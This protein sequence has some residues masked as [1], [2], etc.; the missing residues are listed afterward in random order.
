MNSKTGNLIGFV[1]MI[2]FM[3]IVFISDNLPNNSSP[4]PTPTPNQPQEVSPV[5]DWMTGPWPPLSESDPAELSEAPLATNYY[6]I[7]DASGSMGDLVGGREKMSSAKHALGAFSNSVPAG[8]NVGLMTFSPPQERL[9]IAPHQPSLF[10]DTVLGVF[11][12]GRT[13]L[14]TSIKRGF[15]ALTEQAIRQSGYGRYI[16]LIVTDGRS[17]DGDPSHF[18]RK[19]VQSSAIEV[20][21]VGFGLNRHALKMPGITEYHVANS[22]DELVG[23]LES[24]VASETEA[25]VDPTDFNSAL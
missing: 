23:A 7:L 22:I 5:P 4:S 12:G 15:D 16:L 25:F 18:A 1:A 19:I 14:V 24:V 13:P 20:V 10:T 9:P 21:V 17:S 2:I 11:P 6:V 3:I 8:S